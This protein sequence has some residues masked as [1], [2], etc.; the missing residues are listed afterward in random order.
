MSFQYNKKN[1]SKSQRLPPGLPSPKS[2]H[3][4]DSR[5]TRIADSRHTRV[6]WRQ[7]P[8]APAP[9]APATGSPLMKRDMAS[10]MVNAVPFLLFDNEK[11]WLP[12]YTLSPRYQHP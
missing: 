4:A 10:A 6:A 3:V 8:K 5:H 2:R 7:R 11:I 12:E 9:I 1:T